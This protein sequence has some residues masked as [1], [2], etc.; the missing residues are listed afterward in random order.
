M[1]SALGEYAE[2]KHFYLDVTSNRTGRLDSSLSQQE[3]AEFVTAF[4]QTRRSHSTGA[5][6]DHIF[7][8]TRVH[9]V[10]DFSPC[11]I[12]T[13]CILIGT[14]PTEDDNSI[15]PLRDTCGCATHNTMDKAVRGALIESV[16]RQL[17]L[18]FWLTKQCN[19]AMTKN[20]VAQT[21]A[22]SPVR[23]LYDELN[24]S[25]EVRVLD[26]SS[27]D[28]PGKCI[29]ICYGSPGVRDVNYCAGLSYSSNILIAAEKALVELWQ[30]FRF[31]KSFA[32]NGRKASDLTDP[33]IRHF[34][35]CNNYATY[36]EV[37]DCQATNSIESNDALITA[38]NMIEC[39]R[40]LQL[41]GYLYMKSI[42]HESAY[43]HFCKYISPNVFLHMNNS[44]SINMRNRY[45]DTFFESV[46]PARVAVMV[47]FP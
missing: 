27:G 34:M 11:D 4:A 40:K 47:P 2:R 32:G 15:V 44:S 21:L 31:M 9:R 6:E 42:K 20:F 19:I 5:I 37:T 18:K 1:D 3:V 7:S 26:I 23:H 45:C 38:Q 22:V 43:A 46:I 29:F 16:E 33:Y 28:F 30:T 12:P 8:L 25:G 41:N 14:S 17:L 35:G 13:T 10:T 36:L 24:K 39:L